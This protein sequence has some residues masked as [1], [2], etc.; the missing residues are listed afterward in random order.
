MV[1]GTRSDLQVAEYLPPAQSC[2]FESCGK[3]GQKMWWSLWFALL[4]LGPWL[5]WIQP[6]EPLVAVFGWYLHHVSSKHHAFLGPAIQANERLS[7]SEFHLKSVSTVR[8]I[9]SESSFTNGEYWS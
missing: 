1:F 4:S 7:E 5:G 9:L 8:Q 6:S 3:L 2:W